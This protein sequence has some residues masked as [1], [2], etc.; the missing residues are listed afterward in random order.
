MSVTKRLR[1]LW[2]FAIL[3][4]FAISAQAHAQVRDQSQAAGQCSDSA[5][6]AIETLDLDR[7][8]ISKIK[9]DPQYLP[10]SG[11]MV[12]GVNFWLSSDTCRGSLI[13]VFSSD[14]RYVNNYTRGQCKLSN[15]TQP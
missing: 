11:N 14:C 15:F 8:R 6:A 2:R 12:T 10:R 1:F 5:N 4:V 7:S 3:A 13:L 9:T